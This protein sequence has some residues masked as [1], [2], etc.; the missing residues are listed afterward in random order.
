MGAAAVDVDDVVGGVEEEVETVTMRLDQ[1]LLLETDDSC[2]MCGHRGTG[3]LTIHHIDGD[4]DHSEYDNMIVLCHNCHVSHNKGC[5]P[6]RE[7]I[8]ERKKRLI[9][10][11]LTQYGLNALKIASRNGVGVIALPFL[12]FHLVELGFMTKEETQM[13]YDNIEATALFVI[14][15]RGKDLVGKWFT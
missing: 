2:A 13:E 3:V 1:M 14:T 8:E 10:K 12:L 4:R 7:A 6:T 11:T 15:L 5:G 9:A